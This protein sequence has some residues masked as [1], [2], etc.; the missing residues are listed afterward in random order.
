MSD[1]VLPAEQLVAVGDAGVEEGDVEL[2]VVLV[3]VRE[4]L[5]DLLLI[6]DVARKGVRVLQRN[7]SS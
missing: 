1:C 2:R 4:Q 5:L 7:L 3:D 6:G